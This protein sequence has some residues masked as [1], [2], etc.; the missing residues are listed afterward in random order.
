ML[1]RIVNV[2]YNDLIWSR[3]IWMKLKLFQRKKKL[4]PVTIIWKASDQ[5][6]Q[7]L[8][9]CTQVL[10]WIDSRDKCHHWDSRSV[11][12]MRRPGDSEHLR[13][14]RGHKT[15]QWSASI[16]DYRW[17]LSEIYLKVQQTEILYL[18]CNVSIPE[19]RMVTSVVSEDVPRMLDAWHV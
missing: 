2:K 9:T 11:L 12:D 8:L 19:S 6:Y 5:K 14:Y 10:Q 7:V 4:Q 18:Q 16:T 3:L 15:H 17:S 1:A 13:Q